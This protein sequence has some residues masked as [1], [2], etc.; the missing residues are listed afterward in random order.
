MVYTCPTG[1]VNLF[2]RKECTRFESFSPR[3]EA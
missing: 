2:F 3:L 1:T